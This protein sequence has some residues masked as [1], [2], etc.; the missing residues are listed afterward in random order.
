MVNCFST[1]IWAMCE[2]GWLCVSHNT[3]KAIVD[4]FSTH[5]WAMSYSDN[6]YIKRKACQQ[7]YHTGLSSC[8]LYILNMLHIAWTGDFIGHLSRRWCHAVRVLYVILW[9]TERSAGWS[10]WGLTE[11]CVCCD[12]TY[13]HNESTAYQCWH[14]CSVMSECRYFISYTRT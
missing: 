3:T 7:S 13:D 6:S 8:R 9:V 11:K 12:Y 10:Y 14:I 1:H 2:R 5:I 4:C